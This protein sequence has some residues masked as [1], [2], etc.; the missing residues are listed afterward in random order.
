MAFK[1]IVVGF[2]WT[3]RYYNM[4]LFPRCFLL[5]LYIF[6]VYDKEVPLKRWNYWVT[7]DSLLDYLSHGI[8][9]HSWNWA[10]GSNSWSAFLQFIKS[11]FQIWTQILNMNASS[12][13]K[14]KGKQM[15][16]GF[17]G[18]CGVLF[19]GWVFFLFHTLLHLRYINVKH[20]LNSDFS[21]PAEPYLFLF[22]IS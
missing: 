1:I 5:P 8:N 9:K 15:V 14:K 11:S 19:F 17:F 4:N 13:A 21:G 10:A 2:P 12:Q 7:W 20:I 3:Q 18:G 6:T 22:S 16:V